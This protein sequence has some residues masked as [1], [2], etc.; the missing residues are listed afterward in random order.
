MSSGIDHCLST[1]TG[2]LLMRTLVKICPVADSDSA[3][4]T[5]RQLRDMGDLSFTQ[6]AELR[7][8]GAFSTVSQ[9]FTTCCVRCNTGS[10]AASG[11]LQEWYQVSFIMLKGL[12]ESNSL[13]S[14]QY[15]AFRT[16]PLSTLGARQDCH[17][18]WSVS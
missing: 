2:S 7:H 8:R 5:P 11:T 14:E 15:F 1:N 10:E 17:L 18:S 12:R 16:R 6:L 13:S 9:T 4:M 3:L